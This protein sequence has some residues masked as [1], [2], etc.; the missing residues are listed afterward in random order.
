M[1]NKGDKKMDTD[2]T[3]TIHTYKI[4]STKAYEI[5]VEDFCGSIRKI[6]NEEAYKITFPICF[7]SYV[8]DE[9][10]ATSMF[11][12]RVKYVDNILKQG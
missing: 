2:Q 10:R 11:Q 5:V 6:R 7:V 3:I 4:Y 12:E 8:N 9:Q 1:T